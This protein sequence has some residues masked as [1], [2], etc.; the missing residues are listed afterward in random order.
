M[1]ASSLVTSLAVDKD[2]EMLASVVAGEGRA[3][4]GGGEVA[5]MPLYFL[6]VGLLLGAL[7]LWGHFKFVPWFPYNAAMFLEGIALGVL[8]YAV[9]LGE[10]ST[11]IESWITIDPFLLMAVFLP[12]LIFSDV[13]RINMHQFLTTAFLPACILAI[14]GVVISGCLMGVAAN[15]TLGYEWD[16]YACF[17]FGTVMGAT[18]PVSIVALLESSG[19]PSRLTLLM[20]SESHLADLSVLAIFNVFLKIVTDGSYFLSKPNKIAKYV[21]KLLFVAPLVG[22]VFGLVG[23][24]A[25][26]QSVSPTRSSDVMT[27]ITITIVTAYLS[28]LVSEH[29][30]GSNGIIASVFAA[31]VFAKYA[32]PKFAQRETMEN[33][34]SAIEYIGNTLI[35]LLA[36][37]I[38]GGNTYNALEASNLTGRDF[39]NVFIMWF[40]LFLSRFVVVI[41]LFPLLMWATKKNFTLQDAA[42]TIAGGVRGAVTITLAIVV[43]NSTDNTDYEDELTIHF[44]SDYEAALSKFFFVVGCIVLLTITVNQIIFVH[45]LKF[46]KLTNNT[47]AQETLHKYVEKRV[48]ANAIAVVK[49]MQEDPT[50]RNVRLEDVADLVQIEKLKDEERARD[51]ASSPD[52]PDKDE[53]YEAFEA[54]VNKYA[55]KAKNEDLLCSVRTMFLDLVRA[56]YWDQIKGGR[57]PRKSEAAVILLDAVDIAGD[58]VKVKLDDL[59]P[60]R[61]KN[62]LSASPFLERL[63][64]VIDACLPE[65][66]VF[67]NYLQSRLINARRE[68]AVYMAT[69]YMEAHAA[70]E[71]KLAEYLGESAKVDTPEEATVIQESMNLREHAEDLLTHAFMDNKEVVKHVHLIKV[72]NA[73]VESEVRYIQDLADQ[74]IIDAKF[75]EECMEKIREKQSNIAASRR[76]GFHQIAVVSSSRKAISTQV[77]SVDSADATDDSEV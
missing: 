59:S 7:S 49:T 22:I 29:N 6:F 53:S 34:W 47:E 46:L 74:G 13:M 36:G 55:K 3:L 26:K 60:L 71:L 30:F 24:F 38:L 54:D 18:D 25:I 58:D 44:G 5:Y 8:H 48:R 63:L 70:A 72:A 76:R 43:L 73:V 17:L 15:L 65:C 56:Q 2:A 35:F 50:Y 37:L 57:L 64:D 68:E 31:A 32:W 9:G 1:S 4:A 62:R 27:Q 51:S 21:S 10:L 66:I 16:W 42:A 67:D 52:S 77:A 75:Q 14:V 23:Y 61:L 28:F 45:L 41:I 39:A 33:V 11:S 19:A 20:S 40:L 69:C 12:S